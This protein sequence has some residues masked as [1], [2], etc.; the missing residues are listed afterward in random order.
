MTHPFLSIFYIY[1]PLYGR[2]LRVLDLYILINTS[3]LF[4]M[5]P[6][7]FTD[8]SDFEEIK[9]K[10]SVADMNKNAGDLAV[11]LSKVSYYYDSI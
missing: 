10:R 11:A 5:L 2:G 6:Y 4:S 9:S 1:S 7:Y 8:N 3:F